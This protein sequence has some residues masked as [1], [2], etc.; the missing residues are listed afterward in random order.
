[1]V[2]IFREQRHDFLNHFQVLL[3]YL[4]LNKPDRAAQ[5]IKQI[6]G[7]MQELSP[8]TKLENPYLVTALLLVLQKSKNVGIQ[9]T[10]H[11]ENQVSLCQDCYE[12]ITDGITRMIERIIQYL[13]A[14]S[15]EDRRIDITLKEIDHTIVMVISGSDI[16]LDKDSI[17]QLASELDQNLMA[18]VSFQ[19][20]KSPD[21][22]RLIFHVPKN[23]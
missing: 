18:E 4:Q 23:K 3:G 6:T 15:G 7:E 8:V 16:L 14:G 12:C 1:M 10:F 5:Y 13:S 19:A 2:N 17:E 9:L 21:E 20:N 22:L 11:V